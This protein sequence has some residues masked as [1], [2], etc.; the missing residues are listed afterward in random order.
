[1]NWRKLIFRFFIISCLI[2]TSCKSESPK[3]GFLLPNFVDERATIERNF[4]VSKVKELGYEPI[5]TDAQ[6]NDQL[7]INQAKNLIKQ[8]VKMLIVMAVNKN[9]AAEIIRMAHKQSIKV[10]AYERIIANCDL[11]YYLSFDNVKVGE[12]I[13]NYVI[14]MKPKGKYIILNGDKNDQNAIWV[15]EG[16]SKV[17]GPL[18]KSG[19]VSIKYNSFIEDW[20]G[21]NAYMETKKYLNLST[22]TPDAIISAYDGMSRGAIKALEENESKYQPI[23]TGQNAELL[24]CK[25]IAKGKQSMTVYKPLKKEAELAAEIAIK[26]LRNEKIETN[27]KIYNGYKDVPSILIEP[28]SV[29]IANI[30]NTVVK[31]GFLKETD[32]FAE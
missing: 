12:L 4:F 30:R 6:F 5:V 21:D 32:I 27:Q 24:S 22:E 28:I 23:I 7:Q 9:T 25:Y 8:G 26:Y 3:I 17:I 14:K 1:M 11:D 15:N 31:D 2:A 19:D 10:I 16:I 13:A 20:S 29:D 18:V